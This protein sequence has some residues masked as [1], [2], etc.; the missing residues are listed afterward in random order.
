MDKSKYTYRF[1][2][3]LDKQE[4]VAPVLKYFYQIASMPH[5]KTG[6]HHVRRF[7]CSNKN[8]IISINEVSNLYLRKD[9]FKKFIKSKKLREYKLYSVYD[10]NN[11]VNYPSD[12][13]ILMLNSD[14]FDND[15]GYNGYAAFNTF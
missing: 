10:L 15:C 7:L 9:K 12:N 8:Q 1:V 3:S 2:D 14:M 5:P 4:I 13:D 11:L 6:L